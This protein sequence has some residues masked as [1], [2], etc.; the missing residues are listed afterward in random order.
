MCI[1]QCKRVSQL[2]I[3]NN[4]SSVW[5]RY[6]PCI[7]ANHLNDA[8]PSGM[9]RKQASGQVDKQNPAESLIISDP[10]QLPPPCNMKPTCFATEMFGQLS[11]LLS[12]HPRLVQNQAVS[13]GC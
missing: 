1:I 9:Y 6:D 2:I 5:L 10:K 8:P 4:N 12:M 13:S 3:K 11:Q 7:L